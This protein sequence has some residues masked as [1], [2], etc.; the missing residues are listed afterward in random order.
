L[1]LLVL[2]ATCAVSSVV[3]KNWL[4]LTREEKHA[5]T[6]AVQALKQS[7]V[8]DD[9]VLMHKTAYDTPCPWGEEDPDTS[10]RNGDQKGPAFLPWHRAQLIMLEHQL[11][12]VSNDSALA[13]PY[14]NW[15]DDSSLADPIHT[16]MWSF[17]GIGGTG[18]PSDDRVVTGPFANWPQKYS[19]NGDAFLTRTLGQVL[20]HPA[21]PEDFAAAFRQ[22]TYDTEPWSADSAVGFRNWVEGFYSS[23]GGGVDTL[24]M[25]SSAHAFIGGSMR[26]STSPNDPVFYML[27]AFTD[28]LWT[29]WQARQLNDNSGS[30][31]LDHFA[32]HKGGPIGHNLDDVLIA[33]GGCTARDVL[34]FTTLPY[35]YDQ[36]PLVQ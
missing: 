17:R 3:R 36:L 5:F 19:T 8:W 27:H 21:R 6:D 14:W 20:S 15:M 28:A 26:W 16:P 7:G 32:P 34:D 10:H 31:V 30:T 12:M 29:T 11:Q 2:F 23:R 25:H 18:R 33:L 9:Y 22:T 4:S 35:T 13:I 1:G 24:S